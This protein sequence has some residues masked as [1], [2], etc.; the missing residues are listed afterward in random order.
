MS[1]ARVGH[2]RRRARREALEGRGVGYADTVQLGRRRGD[3]LVYMMQSPK[4]RVP[5]RTLLKN[6]VYGAVDKAVR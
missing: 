5:Y 2:G 4:Q 6:M 1:E 3:L